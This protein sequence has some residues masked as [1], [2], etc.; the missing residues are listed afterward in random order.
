MT[1]N[2]DIKTSKILI[3]DDVPENLDILLEVLEHEG[4]KIAA[5]PNGELALKVIPRFKPDLV[6]LDIMMP[7]INGIEVCKRVKKDPLISH[8]PIIFITA[9]QETKDLVEGFEVGGVDYITKPF[10]IEEVKIRVQTQLKIRKLLEY[11]ETQT[12]EIKSAYQNLKETRDLLIRSEKLGSLGIL[13][14]GMCHEINNP[15]NFIFGASN[16]IRQETAKIEHTI[17][18]LKDVEGAESLYETLTEG[19]QTIRESLTS[20]KKGTVRISMVIDGLKS[21]SHVHTS[22]RVKIAVNDLLQMVVSDMDFLIHRNIIIKWEFEDIPNLYC[23]SGVLRQVFTHVVQNAVLSMPEKGTLT[24]C[25]SY[26]NEIIV[27]TIKDSG[28]GIEEKNLSKVFNP[29]FTTRK[30]GQGLGLG[31]TLAHNII[32]SM[33][34]QILIDSKVNNGTTVTIRIP[35]IEAMKNG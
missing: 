28:D 9:K 3:V 10:R 12:K 1:E 19:T 14:A 27:I 11:K 17:K 35:L 2:I 20:I 23:E 26:N 22:T 21:F 31:L 25:T 30:V 6:L 16:V 7:G 34:G 15:T 4:Y 13:A 8:I 32:D 18:P 5:A 29:F 24:I 33:N